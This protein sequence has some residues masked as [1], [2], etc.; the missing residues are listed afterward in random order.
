MQ[1]L[2]KI[3]RLK[4][5][6]TLFGTQISSAAYIF[7]ILK[8]LR[9]SP[10]SS[11][12]HVLCLKMVLTSLIFP[13]LSSS[14]W[15]IQG[16]CNWIQFVSGHIKRRPTKTNLF[17]EKLYLKSILVNHVQINEGLKKLKEWSIYKTFKL[18]DLP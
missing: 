16:K 12:N 14:P 2:T 4:E 9:N 7:S 13:F 18:I 17:T 15:F 10:I 5:T 6:L 3:L 1:I 8:I 11:K